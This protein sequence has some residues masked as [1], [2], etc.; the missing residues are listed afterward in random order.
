MN[1]FDKMFEA[2]AHQLIDQAQKVAGEVAGKT[3]MPF[4]D[5]MVAGVNRFIDSNQAAFV[6]GLSAK[7]K[8]LLSKFFAGQSTV[9]DVR[10]ALN[11][12]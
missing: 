4:D 6:A 12:K 3:R 7:L 5:W 8:D 10:N 11:A 1:D 9:D 2:M